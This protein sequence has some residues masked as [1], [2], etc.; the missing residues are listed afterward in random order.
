MAK[1][2]ISYQ[3]LNISQR[4]KIASTVHDS[5]VCVVPAAEEKAAVDFIRENMT[6]VPDWAEGLP[7][8][9]EVSIGK[10]YG[11]LKLIRSDQEQTYQILFKYIYLA[12]SIY[13]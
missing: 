9:C 13:V 4:Y 3:M 7:L 8:N 5:I 6:M 1:I 12:L 11:E 10:N 2:I